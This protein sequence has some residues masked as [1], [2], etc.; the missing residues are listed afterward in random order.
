VGSD[1]EEATGPVDARQLRYFLAVVDEGGFGRAADQLFIAQPSLSQA[2]AGLERELGVTLFHRVGRTVVLSEAGRTLLGPA[3]LVLR[4]LDAAR[5]SVDALR[6][7]RSGRLEMA[8]MPSPGIEPLTTLIA[9]FT[10]RHPLVTLNVEGVFTPEEVVDAVRTGRCELGLTGARE[11]VKVAGV[12]VLALEDQPLILLVS[13]TRDTFGEVESI[14]GEA[15][16]GHRIVASQQGSLMRWMVDDVLAGG[17]DCAIV[18]EVAHRTSILPMVLSGVGHAVMPSSWRQLAE[19][20]GLR[21]LTITPEVML[22]VALLSRPTGLTPA[23]ESFLKVARR[24]A[25]HS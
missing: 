18:A 12:D 3:R 13:P 22:H 20:S 25:D 16:S 14:T 2:I 23:A 11:P 5:A 15:L 6:G 4:D 9:E 10:T 24:Y 21:T 17:V 19:R 7:V 8:T 1:A